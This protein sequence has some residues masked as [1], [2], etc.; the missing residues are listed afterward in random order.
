ME[1]INKSPQPIKDY[2]QQLLDE[3]WKEDSN[4]FKS[5]MALHKHLDETPLEELEKEWA[6][7]DKL[8]YKG[9]TVEEYFQGINPQYQYQKGY[10]DGAK[11]LMDKV[12]GKLKEKDDEMVQIPIFEVIMLIKK[13]YDEE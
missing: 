2:R 12:I 10:S 3:G 11:S 13:I 6:E 9:P 8:G 4:E 1:N 5:L 7:I